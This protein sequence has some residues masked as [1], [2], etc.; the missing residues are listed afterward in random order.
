MKAWEQDRDIRLNAVPKPFEEKP[1]D[2]SFVDG[3]LKAR[4]NMMAKFWK[5]EV[6]GS[7]APEIPFMEM[8]QA[9]HN[10]GYDVSE[11]EQWLSVGRDAREQNDH[12]TMEVLGARIQQAL[13]NA[14]KDESSVYW[15]YQAPET[16]E[17]IRAACPAVD[18]LDGDTAGHCLSEKVY[19]GWLG[20]IAGGAYGTALEG[21]SG[22]QLNAFYG[23]RLN[24]YVREP[25][26][27][28]DDVTYE[29]CVLEAARKNANFSSQDIAEEWLRYIPYG[30]SA[31]HFALENL[32]RGIMP[33]QSGT[34]LNF[35]SEW[36]GAQM[37]TMV[38]GMLAPGKPWRAAELAYRDSVIS[39][40]KN[41]VY[42]GIHAAVLT[43]LAFIMDD[44]RAVVRASRGYIPDNTLFAHLF[45]RTVELSEQYGDHREVWQSMKQ[46]ELRT[47][48]WIHTF[49]NMVAVVLSLWFCDNNFTR[50]MR[51]LGDCGEDVDCNAGE[52]GTVLGVMNPAC[53]TPEWAEPLADQ[54][55][56]Y[57]PGYE[58]V[59]IS[60]LARQTVA[61]I[62]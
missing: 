56:T 60:E 45:D 28:N 8:I 17:A 52:V 41:G 16:F 57:V 22:E 19:G 31:E 55:E 54:L 32:R 37:R 38:H 5:S 15:Q 20:Q 18:K 44:A 49:P 58:K 29:L 43:S 59:R 53:V 26:T 36:I 33:P 7:N 14:P 61:L 39:H 34:C 27:M 50:A 10:R 51:I 48:N 62:S 13:A 30:W 9:W 1:S 47:Y 4:R 23:D 21:F 24:G 46:N 11:A 35:Y 12:G 6:P 25:E 40:E 3:I 2:W 42:G